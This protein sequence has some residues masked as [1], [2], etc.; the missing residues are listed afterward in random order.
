MTEVTPARIG[1]DRVTT[2]DEIAVRSP[3]DGSEVGRVPACDAGHVDRAV[4]AARAHL[5]RPWPAHERAAVLDRAAGLLAE[6][7]ED[8]AQTIAA[9]AAKPL[10]T[11]RVEAAR[12]VDTFRFSAA[13]AR[14]Q[15]GEVVP[16]DASPAGEGKVGFTLRVPI[17]V[18]AAVSPFNFPL[19]LVGHKVAPAIAAGCPVVL[20]PASQTPLSAL[21][22]AALLLDECG[23]PAGALNVVT[24]SG[25]AV[26]DP[27][28]TH[29]DVAMVTFTG[30]PEVGWAIRGKAVR[31]KVS[32]ELGNNSPVIIA[33]DGD[34]RAAVAKLRV[35]GFSHAGQSC[36]SAQRVYVHRSIHDDVVAAL[37]DAVGS[38]VVGPPLA[39]ETD[40]SSLISPRD[41]ER[42]RSWIDE[43][44][45]GGAKVA[46]GG[47]VAADGV[48]RPTVLTGVTAGMRV[49]RDEV[50][51]PVL[52]VAAYDDLDEAVALA[53]DTRYGLQAG[54]FTARL[55]TALAAA[56]ALDFG[57]VL[58][59]EVPTWRADQQPYGGVRDSGNTREGPRHAVREMTE[60]RLVVLQG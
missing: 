23:L 25:S 52:G 32:L 22:L 58:V 21:A 24:G 38:L 16:L 43:A 18:V 48:L 57:G 53:N 50:F 13:E 37:V 33:A 41:T 56:R 51:G 4:A 10:R 39:E 19:N 15:A 45:A 20:K 26:G 44:V 55:D 9:E 31:K 47:E 30:S 36:I 6:R 27:L 28:V 42:V 54:I 11:A 8:F 5:A 35:A 29:D 12:A 14:T 1:A 2:G 60:T 34:W 59:N 40:V 49:C 17:G 3:Y 7:L 46:I